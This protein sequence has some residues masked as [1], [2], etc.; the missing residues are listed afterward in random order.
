MELKSI[1]NEMR[2]NI[3]TDALPYMRKYK[4]KVVVVKYG[5]NAMVNDELKEAV[6]SDVSLLALAGVKVILVHGGGPE[7]NKMLNKL[8]IE[9]HFVGGLRYTDADTM[10]VVQMV[11]AGK[12]NKDLVGL[13]G[14]LGGRAIG[15]SGL[16][17]FMLQARKHEEED[18]GYVGDV[19]HVDVEPLNVLLD[20]GY[21]PV[22]STIGMDEFGQAYNINADTAAAAIAVAMGAENLILMT[23]VPG[24]MRDMN[25]PSSLITELYSETVP[26]LIE[27]GVISGG[28]IPKAICC[29]NAVDNGV[30]KAV[31]IDGRVPHAILVEMLSN[32]GVGTLIRKWKRN[33]R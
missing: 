7:I 20:A 10:S 24:L 9:S 12:T 14:K 30:K 25:D 18:L 5:G 4:G 3:L 28:M 23:D 26:S 2:A 6:M 27:E 13:I 11:L 1:S 17:G 31:M 29:M 19:T 33:G 32:E 16:D 15:L 22:V 21:V 8:N